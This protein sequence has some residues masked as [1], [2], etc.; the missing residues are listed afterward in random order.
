LN[1]D[2]SRDTGFVTG[3]GFNSTVEAI[4][5]QSDGKILVGGFFT[6]YDG[7]TQNRI[8]RLNSDGSRDTGFVIGT[9]FNSTV[10][11]IALQSDGKILVG[12][13]FTLYNG[14]AEIYITRL[15]TDGSRDTGFVTFT[16]TGFSSTVRVIVVQPNGKIL[17]GGDFTSYKGVTRRRIAILNT[18]GSSPTELDNV[19]E[20]SPYNFV[21]TTANVSDSTALRW[22][23]LDRPNDFAVNTGTVTIT[24]NSGTFSVTPT[25]D[26]STEGSE[27]FRVQVEKTSGSVVSTTGN[28]T[29]NDTST[30]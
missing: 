8:T 11:V 27:T 7:V 2:G 30:S 26:E 20:G 18:D 22:R 13:S 5:V 29:I 6:T 23:I 14:G 24:A 28:L 15:N 12:G 21:M 25:A 17:V 19:N 9:G 4:A 10:N 3:T 1:S 16:S